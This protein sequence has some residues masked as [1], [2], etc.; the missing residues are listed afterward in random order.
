MKPRQHQP[1]KENLPRSPLF[2]CHAARLQP[3]QPPSEST[4]RPCPLRVHPIAERL[5]PRAVAIDPAV[6]VI[7]PHSKQLEV[8]RVPILH[9]AH[10]ELETQARER[11]S[12]VIGELAAPLLPPLP[13]HPLAKHRARRVE[14][15]DLAVTVTHLE[16]HQIP[17]VALPPFDPRVPNDTRLLKLSLAHCV[18]GVCLTH[19]LLAAQP[20]KQASVLRGQAQA[21][22]CRLVV[23]H[24]FEHCIP[25]SPIQIRS[26]PPPLV[27]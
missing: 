5:P 7:H 12:E 9:V 18:E 21:A 17:H 11:L 10:A 4:A 16:H 15:G 27:C 25:L 3:R 19:L 8:F 2:E 26:P 23:E 14:L 20:A 1:F 6:T 13:Q 22:V 24:L